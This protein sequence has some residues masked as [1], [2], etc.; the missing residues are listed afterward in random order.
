[1]EL[2]KFRKMTAETKVYYQGKKLNC[3]H[4]SSKK[5]TR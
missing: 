3:D 5:L 4:S 1:M 2:D